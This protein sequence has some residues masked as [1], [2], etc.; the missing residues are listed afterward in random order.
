MIKNLEEAQERLASIRQSYEKKLDSK[1][2]ISS[3]KINQSYSSRDIQKGKDI[4]KCSIY[5]IAQGKHLSTIRPR[6]SIT[7]VLRPSD[8][9][10]KPSQKAIEERKAEMLKS[11]QDSRKKERMQDLGRTR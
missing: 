2:E 10:H 7:V 8:R 6:E 3:V 1:T 11:M 5:D 9:P 4:M